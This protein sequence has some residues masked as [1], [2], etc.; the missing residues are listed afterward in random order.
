MEVGKDN[1][2]VSGGAPRDGRMLHDGPLHVKIMHR[3]SLWTMTSSF[4]VPVPQEDVMGRMGHSFT[5]ARL[6]RYCTHKSQL[7]FS[8]HRDLENVVQSQLWI[9]SEHNLIAGDIQYHAR[10][11]VYIPISALVF[12]QLLQCLRCS[13]ARLCVVIDL[14]CILRRGRRDGL[15]LF[16]LVRRDGVGLVYVGGHCFKH[17]ETHDDAD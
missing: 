11:R 16:R 8:R 1:L 17:A 7:S 6:D 2:G 10:V 13:Y 5:Q 14:S 12:D 3:C 15:G 4:D 9:D